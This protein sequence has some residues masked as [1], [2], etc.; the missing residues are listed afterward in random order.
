M[1][2]DYVISLRPLWRK[3]YDLKSSNFSE[4]LKIK[5]SEEVEKYIEEYTKKYKMR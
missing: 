1:E 4:E 2:D 5:F 3:Y